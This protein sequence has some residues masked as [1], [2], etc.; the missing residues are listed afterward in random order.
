MTADRDRLAASIRSY[1]IPRAD[2][3]SGPLTV[4]FAGPTGSGKSTLINSVT[5]SDVSRAG[6]LRPTTRV[7]VVVSSIERAPDYEMVGRVPCEVVTGRARI[8]Q[9]M[10][11]V[12]TPDID[13]TS[14]NHRE[15][16]ETLV[17]NADV[18]V[19]VT[20]ALRYADA[21]PWQVLR[22][23]V[24]RGTDVIQ[25]LNRVSS[26]TAGAVV[27]FK[28][29]LRAAGMGDEVVTIPEHHIAP[30][31]QK[32]PTLA[33]KTL[34]NR[35]TEIA[36]ARDADDESTFDRVLWAIMG[37]VDD[38]SHGVIEV[39]EEREEL[40]ARLAVDMSERVSDLSLLGVGSGLVSAFPAGGRRSR[41]A[42][43][44]KANRGG[45]DA[46]EHDVDRVVTQVEVLV[47]SDL[48][49]W[50]AE[51]RTELALGEGPLAFSIDSIRPTIRSV[52]EGW[53]DYV[54]RIVEAGDSL[55][56]RLEVAVLLDAAS[57]E[58]P[59]TA[60][61]EALFGYEA[62]V[63]V[64]R[65]RR[66]LSGRLEMIYEQAAMLVADTLRPGQDRLDEAGLRAALGAVESALTPV[67]A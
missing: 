18:V 17:D 7:P 54:R 66:E 24:A 31:E 51:Q 12:D 2:D 56:Q 5:G 15:D 47:E 10:A 52:I 29:R 38:L 19:F 48:R 63:F 57:S 28:T 27:D 64:E 14:S 9:R 42:R 23:A 58:S 13:S 36:I 43:W 50:L 25:V 11:F 40:E 55:D 49:S 1:L 8:L 35:L 41:V 33:V 16:A 3:P 20:S 53:T 32:L 67:Y 37:Q 22:R 65:A 60:E 46:Y 62:P 39:R 59:T 26:S 4:V 61:A 34:R 6:V 44:K 21:V 30:G 45:E